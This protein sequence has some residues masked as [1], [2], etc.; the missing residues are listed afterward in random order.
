[1][2]LVA[3]KRDRDDDGGRREEEEE[4]GGERMD[5]I[6]SYTFFFAHHLI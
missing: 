6:T 3:C 2:L 5:S 1:M 4:R